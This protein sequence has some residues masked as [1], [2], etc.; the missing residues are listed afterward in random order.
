MEL[1]PQASELNSIIKEN[2]PTVYELLSNRGRGIFFPK[3]GILAQ[4]ADAKGK[5]INATIGAAIEDDGTPMNLKSI[6]SSVNLD[7]KNFIPYAP[8]FGREELRIKWK[9][10]LKKKNDR[11]ANLEF[12][13]PI[14]T[15]AITHGLSVAGYLFVD[16]D[17]EIISPD[18]F[19]GNYNLV[20]GVSP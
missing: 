16:P 9:E 7:V 8:S 12:S 3:K 5:K 14:V 17:D 13:L 4:T 19:W 6:S 11:L 10:L 1:N 18:L 2:S 20:F 15:N